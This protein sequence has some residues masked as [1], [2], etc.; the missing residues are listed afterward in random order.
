VET[1]PLLW[2][3]TGATVVAYDRAGFGKSDLPETKYDLHED[4][5]ALWRGL[6]APGNRSESHS[7]R[8]LVRR[9][10]DPLRGRRTSAS[11]KGLV[12]VD[13][14]TFEFVDA[15][16]VEE[17]DKMMARFRSMRRSPEKLTK[18]QRPR[19]E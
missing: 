18:Y 16:G 7:R 4:T 9:L 19:S 13:P 14:F 10:P 11:V 2:R 8:A 17:T 1:L 15:T 3:E 5:E 6:K 12:F